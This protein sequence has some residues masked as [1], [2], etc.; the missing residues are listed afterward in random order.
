MDELAQNLVPTEELLF[1]TEKVNIKPYLSQAQ[2]LAGGRVASHTDMRPSGARVIDINGAMAVTDRRIFVM[3]MEGV[4]SK[5]P[6]LKFEAVF[7]SNYAEALIES[8]KEKNEGITQQAQGMGM[9]ARGKFMKEQGYSATLNILTG[10][11]S[12]TSLLGGGSLVLQ[13]FTLH[14]SRLGQKGKDVGRKLGKIFSWGTFDADKLHFELRIK[15]P[16]ITVK[17]VAESVIGATHPVLYE[18]VNRYAGQT[19]VTYAPLVDI[20][21]VKSQEIEGLVKEFEKSAA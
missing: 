2:R 20:M 14:M 12:K 17:K 7:D 5:K 21:Q 4:F 11:E 18:I 15:Q 1:S 16:L 19:N 8:T 10:V 6:V 13:I 3:G 9:F